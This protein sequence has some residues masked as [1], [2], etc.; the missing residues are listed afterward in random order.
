MVG[1]L[2]VL[3]IAFVYLPVLNSWFG[4]APV[5]FFGWMIPLAFAVVIFVLMEVVKAMLRFREASA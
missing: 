3:Q 4:S 5:G 2:V 1:I